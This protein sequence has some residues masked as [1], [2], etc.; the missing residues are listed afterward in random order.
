MAPVTSQSPQSFQDY[1]IL[2]KRELSKSLIS[3]PFGPSNLLV[4]VDSLSRPAHLLKRELPEIGQKAQKSLSKPSQWEQVS[5]KFGL[6][7]LESGGNNSQSQKLLRQT[8]KVKGIKILASRAIWK[9]YNMKGL[10]PR[11][12][13]CLCS[14]V[15]SMPTKTMSGSSSSRREG[16]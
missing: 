3:R 9:W 13:D 2:T 4:I 12:P 6:S 8:V 16:D 14:C 5:L 1:H 10:L 7:R 11:P 15:W